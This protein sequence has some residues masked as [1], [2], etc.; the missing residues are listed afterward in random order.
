VTDR[1]AAANQGAVLK[2]SGMGVA[3]VVDVRLG[4]PGGIGLTRDGTTLLVSSQNA[5]TGADQVLLVDVATGKTGTASK[6]IGANH[7]SSG[8][9]HRAYRSTVFA[10]ADTRRSGM[11]YRVEP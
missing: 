7:N 2:V 1:G 8:G 11:V 9:L 3:K 5:G 10:W 6:V 4:D